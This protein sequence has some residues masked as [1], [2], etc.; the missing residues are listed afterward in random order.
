M[1]TIEYRGYTITS[2]VKD[3][4]LYY[5]INEESTLYKS[6]KEAKLVVD[7]RIEACKEE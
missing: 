1:T 4:H 2:V 6:S 7:N 3:E 5:K